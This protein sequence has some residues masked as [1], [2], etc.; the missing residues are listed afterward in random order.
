MLWHQY[1]VDNRISFNDC[2]QVTVRDLRLYCGAGMGLVT[3]GGKDF[4][5][6]NIHIVRSPGKDRLMSVA[7][8]GMILDL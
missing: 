6:E 4:L 8:D 1:Y 5:F 2:E 3:I 7:A